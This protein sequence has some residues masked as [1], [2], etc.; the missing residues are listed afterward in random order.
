[1]NSQASGIAAIQIETEIESKIES[2]AN[3][4]V[5]EPLGTPS[6]PGN[7]RCAIKTTCPYCGTGCG[8]TVNVSSKTVSTESISTESASTQS[9]PQLSLSGDDDHPTN[10]GKLCSKGINLLETL[11]PAARLLYPQLNGQRVSWDT[12]LDSAA[13]QIRSIIDQHGP[14]AFAI[15]CSGQLLTEDYYVANK[16]MKGFIG[17]ANID[18]NSR[19]CMSSAV[20]GHKRAFGSDTVPGCYDDL[21]QAELMVLTGSNLAWCHPILFQR[22][23]T[24]KERTAKERAATEHVAKAGTPLHRLVVIDP[25]RTATCD[26][27]DLHLA[28]KPGSDATLFNG[29][30]VYLADHQQLDRAFI[31]QHCGDFEAALDQARSSAPDSASVA[32]SCELDVEA[33]ETFYRWFGETPKAVTAFSQG[34]NQSSSGT[35]KVNAIINVHLAT[36]RIGKPGMGP[37]SIT[38]QPNAMGGREVGGLANQLAAHLELNDPQHRDLVGRFWHSDQVA[39][40]PGHKAVDLFRAIESGKVKAVWILATNPVDSL[41]DADRV[42]AAL[43]QCPLVIHSDC[44]AATDTGALAHIRLPASGWGERDGT[45][46]NAER[47]ISRQRA[48]SPASGEARPDWWALSQLG[49]RLGFKNDFDYQAPWQIFR[50]HARLSAFENHPGG[51]RRAFNLAALAEI[52]ADGYEALAPTCWPIM[53]QSAEGVPEG[54]ARLF[55]DGQFFTPDGRAQFVAIRPRGPINA[56]DASYPLVLNTGRIRDQWHTMTR[57]GLSPRLSAHRPEPLVE[58]H[59]AEAAQLALSEGAIARIESRWGAMLARVQITDSIGCGQLFVPMHWT[60]QFSTLGRMGPLVNPEVD[61]LSG[62]P[63]SKQT[64]V[65]ISPFAARWHGF[66][67]SR[68]PLPPIAPS[69]CAYQVRATGAGFHRYELADTAP[70]A[71]WPLQARLW[72]GQGEQGEWLEMSDP[73]RGV[74]RSALV[75]EGRLQAVLVT[76]ASPQLPEREWLGSLFRQARLDERDRRGLLSA[77]PPSGAASAGPIVCACFGVGRNRILKAIREQGLDSAEALGCVLKAG[78]NCGSCVPELRQLLQLSQRETADA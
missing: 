64:P 48:I 29:L 70:M 50:E 8:V 60:A 20:A 22:I 47:C 45:V 32:R 35:D 46:T 74:Y 11:D 10:S 21:D 43:E 73:D 76:G 25:R 3:V 23:R 12:A 38:G 30:L 39:S 33:V 5:F 49:Q 7:P 67:L 1:M 63:E 34:I 57:T 14:D 69:L 77:R 36:G 13:S 6:T 51:I 66:L 37:F 28:L 17:S 44:M 27:A 4:P 16:L 52:D 42:R 54:T 2:K 78:T 72:L 53:T 9:A 71:D 41:P 56:T 62:Q 55:G 59:P 31:D 68:E 15:Y 75:L 24:A 61:P 18:T 65:R 19:L 40:H 26:L 58:I